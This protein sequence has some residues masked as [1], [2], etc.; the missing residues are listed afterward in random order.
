M[1]LF[2]RRKKSADDSVTD[3]TETENVEASDESTQDAE[4]DT[5]PEA[6]APT[7]GISVQAFRGVG[8]QAGPEV[9]LTETDAPTADPTAGGA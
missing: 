5:A 9:S 1:A 8:A 4:T 7:I 2:S 3:P 6:A